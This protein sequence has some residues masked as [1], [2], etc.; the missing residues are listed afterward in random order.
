[1]KLQE[2]IAVFTAR[3]NYLHHIVLDGGS[4]RVL[5][6]D[7]QARLHL[8]SDEAW[9]QVTPAQGQQECVTNWH[10]LAW[11]TLE[12]LALGVGEVENDVA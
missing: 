11:E 5:V 12:E 10:P 4:Q 6:L 7:R 1:M 2:L 9:T 3:P 8:Y